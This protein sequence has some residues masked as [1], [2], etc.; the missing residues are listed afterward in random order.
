MDKSSNY[1]SNRWKRFDDWDD[2]PLR[3]DQFA[4][5]D[6]TNGFAAFDGKKDP[7]PSFQI[8][9]GKITYMDGVSIEDLEWLKVLESNSPAVLDF[10]GWLNLT[11]YSKE[12]WMMLKT[13]SWDSEAVAQLKSFD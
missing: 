8:K 12:F 2:R 9:E 4:I 11:K 6:P 5:E 3:H 10:K 13:S 1:E 7:K